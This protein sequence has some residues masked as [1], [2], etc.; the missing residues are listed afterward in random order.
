MIYGLC[1]EGF[2]GKSVRDDLDGPSRGAV[3]ARSGGSKLRG[4]RLGSHGIQISVLHTEKD[5]RS[6]YRVQEMGVR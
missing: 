3:L 1:G 5:T 4:L 6:R 2:D